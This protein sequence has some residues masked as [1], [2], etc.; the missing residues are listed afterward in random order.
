MPRYVVER[1][2]PSGFHVP[3]DAQGAKACLAVVDSNAIDKVTWV[4]SFVSHDRKK[5]FCVYDGPS[6]EAIRRA[7]DRCKLPVAQITEVMVLDPNFNR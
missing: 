7:A 2:F 4:H 3:V 5:T 6:P 1:D